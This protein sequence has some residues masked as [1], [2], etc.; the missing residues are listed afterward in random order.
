MKSH[1]ILEPSAGLLYL[2]DEQGQLQ[3]FELING[4]T[5]ALQNGQLSIGALASFSSH[6]VVRSLVLNPSEAHFNLTF[7][8]Q[9]QI[10]SLVL[11]PVFPAS[12]SALAGG[13]KMKLGSVDLT[14]SRNF[15]TAST[16]NLGVREEDGVPALENAVSQLEWYLL[17]LRH[18]SLAI[19]ME[20]GN[21]RLSTLPVSGGELA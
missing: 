15:L 8:A 4:L 11:T 7:D 2:L 13:G 16:A 6:A 5:I 21:L 3:S 10:L 14:L 18:F 20:A 9:A 19:E 12:S 17:D 1:I